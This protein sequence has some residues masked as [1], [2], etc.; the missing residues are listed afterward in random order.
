MRRRIASGLTGELRNVRDL[1]RPSTDMIAIRL[2]MLKPDG[3]ISTKETADQVQALTDIGV[4]VKLLDLTGEQV[5]I[6]TNVQ[7]ASLRKSRS[8]FSSGRKEHC[9]DTEVQLR[10]ESITMPTYKGFQEEE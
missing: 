3:Y 5:P 9:S 4:K 7:V 1:P 8:Y 6:P 2:S 10:V